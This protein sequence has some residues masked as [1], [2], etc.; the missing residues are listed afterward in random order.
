MTIIKI[1]DNIK[2][3]GCCDCPFCNTDRVL[4][5]GEWTGEL[6]FT[7]LL[8]PTEIV[9]EEDG[10]IRADKPDNCPIISVTQEEGSD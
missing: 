1:K 5:W 4:D 10:D 7:C 3:R 2:V 6:E 8:N 9:C